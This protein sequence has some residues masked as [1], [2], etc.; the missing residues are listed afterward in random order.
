MHS[1]HQCLILRTLF[2]HF[3]IYLNW[4]RPL[5]YTILSHIIHHY[6]CYISFTIWTSSSHFHYYSTVTSMINHYE[7][8]LHHIYSL[9]KPFK[10]PYNSP[11][12][13]LDVVLPHRRQELTEF[14]N[15]DGLTERGFLL[16]LAVKTMVKS[17]ANHVKTMVKSWWNSHLLRK[18]HKMS[19][20]KTMNTLMKTISVIMV[21]SWWT[22]E[23]NWWIIMEM[24]Q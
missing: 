20:V 7:T 2:N 4:T 9:Q 15:A 14:L 5:F 21:K 10:N 12:F 22:M 3:M 1:K 16:H 19:I 24:A 11:S 23:N 18:N 13:L 6:Y 8:I 17:W